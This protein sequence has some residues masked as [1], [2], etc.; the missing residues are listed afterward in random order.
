MDVLAK[1][2]ETTFCN[3]AVFTI[4]W[5]NDENWSVHHVSKNIEQ[6]GYTPEE[7]ISGDLSYAGIVHPDDRE[8]F[9]HSVLQWDWKHTPC[10]FQECRILD[11]KGDVHLVAKFLRGQCDEKGTLQYVEGTI[12]DITQNKSTG[13]FPVSENDYLRNAVNT[14]KEALLFLDNELKIIFANLAFSRLFLTGSSAIEGHSLYAIEDG[15]WNIPILQDRISVLLRDNTEF[16]D[17]EIESYFSNI[18]QRV[19]LISSRIVNTLNNKT[20]MVL[21]AIEDVT[22]N[23]RSAREL[24]TSEAKYSALVEKGNDGIIIVQTDILKFINSKFLEL[25]GFQEDEIINSILLDHVPVDFR[26][27]LAKRCAKALKDERSIKRNYE[28]DFFRKDG[29]VFPAEVSFSFISY[30][31]DPAVMITIRDIAERK[32]AEM[33]LKNSEKKYSTLVEKSNDGIVIIQDDQLVFANNKFIEI[34]GYTLAEAIGKNFTRFLSTEYRRMFIGNSGKKLGKRS[35]NLLKYE[36]EL[37]SKVGKKIP[38]E[39]NSSMIEHE[40]KP[41]YMAIIRDITEQKTREK[42]LLKLIE[43]RKVLENV[44]ESSPAIVFFWKADDKWPVE[45]VSENISQFGYSAKEFM[46]G[47]ILYGDIIHPSD[48]QKIDRGLSRYFQED[49]NNISLE[50]RI[51]TR[52]GEIRWIDERS[53]IKRNPEGEV[54]YLQGI[55]VDI[56][57]RKNANNFMQICSELDTF[58]TPTTDVKEIFQQLIELVTQ[59]KGIDCGELYLVDEVTG[60]L[61]LV[62]HKGLSFRFV[63]STRRYAANSLQARVLK[64]EYPI[65]KL[66]YEINSMTHGKDLGFEGL[67]ATVILPLKYEGN[68]VAVIMLA[69]HTEYAIEQNTRSIIESIVS[70]V[71]PSIGRIRE[72]V[73]FQ[74]D[75]NNLQEIF[76][77]IEDFLFVLDKDGC[78]LHTNSFLCKRLGYSLEELVGLNILNVHPQN[79][80]IEIAAALADILAG[81]LSV[82]SIPFE[83]YIGELIPVEVKATRGNW[84]GH[85]ALICLGREIKEKVV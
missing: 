71:G 24:K 25:T 5:K 17:L 3:N 82:V 77:R 21:L 46:S 50:Y 64:T 56:T 52:S 1:K 36:I 59:V 39:I 13:S 60:D 32:K 8:K 23:K 35:E 68:I 78:I 79:R 73:H 41:A 54:E 37:L 61:N 85:T 53:V 30:E 67:E 75:L 29:S 27:M 22:D 19:L 69:S 4:F 12:V 66:Y 42:E 11:H 58:F 43:V 83:S 45:F 26:R 76:D 84:N 63:N 31:N 6:L 15:Q 80:A 44:I 62:A 9:R 51:L 72:Q 57:E 10:L 48:L 65:Y 7:F 74:K 20:C 49:E 33:Q 18:G 16:S 14:A 28:V 40:G 70:Q 55:I 47:T 81:K 38:A 34:T 2:L